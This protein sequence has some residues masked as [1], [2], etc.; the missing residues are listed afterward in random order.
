MFGEPGDGSVQD[1]SCGHGLLV[2]VDLGVGHAGVVVD[3]GMHEAC[4]DPGVVLPRLDAGAVAGGLA[5]GPALLD[6]DE[7]P[8]AA[9]RDVAELGDIDVDQLAGP[10]PFIPAGWLAAHAVDVREAV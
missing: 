4:A 9:I 2:V 8:A 6:A 7:A 1:R 5:V 10:G 3:H